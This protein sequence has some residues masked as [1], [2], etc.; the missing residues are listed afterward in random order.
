MFDAPPMPKTTL[1]SF[2]LWLLISSLTSL[3]G[4]LNA[5]A[6]T[7]DQMRFFESKVRPL[8]VEHCFECHSGR[9]QKGGLRLD[10][11][12][13][14]LRGG[15]SDPAIVPGKPEDSLLMEAV[16]YEGLEMP[17][18]EPLSQ[19][20][21][22]T[23]EVWIKMGAP[24]PGTDPGKLRVDSSPGF[25]EQ[26][27][28]WWAIR[29]VR[30]PEV[31]S[32]NS[33]WPRNAID[34]FILAAMRQQGLR[35]APEASAETLARR[36]YFDLTGLPPT[37]EQLDEFLHD[38]TPQAYENL[39]DRLLQSPAYG[40]RYA[41]HW[42][43]VVRYADSDGYRADHTRSNAWRYRQYVIDSL[44]DDKPY[45]VFVQEQLAG[46]ELF[47]ND[48]DSLIGTGFL[49][50]GIYEYNNRDV[51]G[52]WDIILNEATDT[53]GDVFLGA[54]MQCARCHDHKFDPI[55]Q[56]DYFALR[57]FLEA[58][59]IDDDGVCAAPESQS[60]FAAKQEEWEQATASIRLQLS[61]L[62]SKYRARA[63]ESA[64]TKFPDSIQ[65]LYRKS[66]EERDPREHQYAELIQQQVEFEYESLD[67]KFS[68]EDKEKI[69]ALRRELKSFDALRPSPLPTARLVRDVGPLAPVTRIPK[70]G[71]EVEPGFLSI[72]GLD[73]PQPRPRGES[74]GRRSQLA[75]WITD[76]E[77][78]LSTRVIVNRV[79]QWHFGRG[80]APN[81]SDF[82]VLGGEPNH[83]K[84]LDWLTSTFVADGWRMKQLHR[85]IVTSATYRQACSHPNS[86][87]FTRLDPNNQWYWRGDVRRLDAEQI[88]DAVLTVSGNLD[89]ST[90]GP[91]SS[92]A[93]KR[94]SIYTLVKRNSR[95]PLL[96]AFDLPSFFTST[97][98]RDTTTSPLQ[99]LLLINSKEMLDHAKKLAATVQ[100]TNK[101]ATIRTLWRRSYAREPS[102]GEI[103]AAKAFLANQSVS[104]PDAHESALRRVTVS[105]FPRSDAPSVVIKPDG[106]SVLQTEHASPLNV[107][108]FTVEAIFELKS[109]FETGSV[110][111]LVSTWNG[112]RKSPGWSFGVTGKGSR[113]KPQ[114]LV[115]HL[116]GSDGNHPVAEAAVFSDQ[117]V[118]LGRPY[119]ASATIRPATADTEGKVDFVLVDLSAVES[120]A[121]QVAMKHSL[122]GGY[123]GSVVAIG[124]RLAGRGGDFDGLIED[125]R[126]TRGDLETGASLLTH[127]D[128]SESTLG[129]WRFDSKAGL[130]LDASPNSHHLIATGADKH[131]V[132]PS[133]HALVDLCHVLLNSSE[134]LYVR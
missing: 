9:S 120:T 83:P 62:E 31:P 123:G 55:L 125:V 108:A 79:W 80:L 26:D 131:F 128:A 86:A 65:P 46:D 12:A 82:G 129:W 64:V 1:R 16:Q 49:T 122:V 73:A 116:F 5:E 44:N 41:R 57:S 22:E 39:I 104:Y 27:R 3:C 91:A 71:T 126:L 38:E 134:F 40:E 111:T 121:S 130:L 81:A 50:H 53:V 54:G 93:K 87:Q 61:E 21:I 51:V 118:E 20:E 77:N 10:S 124:G 66:A 107:D 98:R 48:P 15:E 117:H 112:D 63:V 28:A 99:S 52:H 88:R 110:R 4:Q 25:S 89:P 56:R 34:H 97:P 75:E 96:D 84:L 74:T 35:P 76:S 6:P 8:L 23:F 42:L 18:G 133:H 70:R 85:L 47:P 43:D 119:Y 32:T 7:A 105:K 37:T 78:P 33:K 69:L 103:N 106:K 114:T 59:L 36:V 2:V 58:M 90:G 72:L 29:P 115:M 109:I 13:G 92:A 67:S 11:L 60:E 45:D 132:D 14:M 101:E 30:R 24:W 100:A 17:P 68:K 95:N 19:R 113:R 127:A 102:L 94:R